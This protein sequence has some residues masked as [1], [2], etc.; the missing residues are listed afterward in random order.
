[1]QLIDNVNIIIN[2]GATV[3]FDENLK[4]AACINVQSVFSLLRLAKEMKNIKAFVQV[5]TAYSFCPI[6]E[7]D[8]VVYKPR[9]KAEKLLQIV[10]TWDDDVVTDITNR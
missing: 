10:Q 2:C 6:K 1:M 8:E 9:I 7:I 3:R 5:S 4:K